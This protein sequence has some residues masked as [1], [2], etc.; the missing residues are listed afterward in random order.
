MIFLSAWAEII[1]NHYKQ[2]STCDI[3]ALPLMKG[4]L[5]S[6]GIYYCLTCPKVVKYK[7]VL[8]AQP[9]R[10]TFYLTLLSTCYHKINH[11][12]ILK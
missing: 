9:V 6:T 5:C 7:S 11:T 12:L 2:I 8:A 3:H 1:N 10:D 4:I